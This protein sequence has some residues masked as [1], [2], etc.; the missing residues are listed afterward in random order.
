M[1]ERAN[2]NN[3][4][5]QFMKLSRTN[6]VNEELKETSII[7][8]SGSYDLK[9]PHMEGRLQIDVFTY[10]RKEFILPSYKLDYVSS[11]LISDNV[12][13]YENIKDKCKIIT[14]I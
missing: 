1:H 10:M 14:K 7:L 8:A 9:Y 5:S 12:K 3:C 2:D 4:L 6:V 13:S 11:Y